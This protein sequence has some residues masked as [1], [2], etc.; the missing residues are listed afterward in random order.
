MMSARGRLKLPS[1]QELRD[2]P[3]EHPSGG[4]LGYVPGV[5]DNIESVDQFANLLKVPPAV[6][7]LVEPLKID[8]VVPNCPFK[9]VDRNG[10]MCVMHKRNWYPLRGEMGSAWLGPEF[11]R[12]TKNT[13]RPFHR[14]SSCNCQINACHLMGYCPLGY[15]YV[16]ENKEHRAQVM[17]TVG[18]FSS[19]TKR[20]VA[21]GDL[22][23][24][25]LAL[26]HFFGRH[27]EFNSNGICELKNSGPFADNEGVALNYPPPLQG[28]E[29]YLALEH[30]V[31]DWLRPQ[32]RWCESM[33]LLNPFPLPD[34][35]LAMLV[36]DRRETA[37]LCDIAVSSAC[38]SPSSPRK[39]SPSRAKLRSDSRVWRDRFLGMAER[40]IAQEARAIDAE[41]KKA[42]VQ[43]KYDDLVA[44]FDNM[45]NI[46]DEEIAELRK[47]IA[48]RD[49]KIEEMEKQLIDAKNKKGRPLRYSDLEEGGLLGDFVKDFTFFPSKKANDAF[50][51]MCNHTDG[52]DGSL[53]EGDGYFEN[54]RQYSKIRMP[55][56]RGEVQPPSYDPN[57]MAY[58]AYVAH[59]RASRLSFFTY[60]DEY[61]AWS[62]A[63]RSGMTQSAVRGL[64]GI[65]S[66]KMSDIVHGWTQVIDDA[67]QEMFPRPT[68][69]QMLQA[70][71]DRFYEAD[72]HC[73]TGL[74]LDAFELFVQQA[75]LPGVGSSTHSDYKKHCTAK[76]AG[77]VDVIGCPWDKTV[78]DGYPGAISDKILTIDTKILREVPFGGVAKV[79]KGFIVNNEGAEEGV[80]IDRPQV[81]M[82][83]QVQQS[84]E[85]TAQTQLLGNTRIVVE[86]VNGEM[87]VS[88][89]YLNA[90]IPVTQFGLVSQIVRI[91]Y[92]MQNFKKAVI[93]H[94]GPDEPDPPGGR[95]ARGE[96]RWYGAT[97]GGLSDYRPFVRAWGLKVEIKR[98]AELKIKHPNKSDT[99]ISEMVLAEDWPS[100]LRKSL[101]RI[102]GKDDYGNTRQAAS[103][104]N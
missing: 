73:R 53:P 30:N 42:E 37:K 18:L 17:N 41:A 80:D 70:Y 66:G 90:L 65:S 11:L 54:L 20:R 102:A 39:R 96:I 47:D 14:V 35:I 4:H 23:R 89:R 67:L 22:K 71:P 77:G 84:A 19:E 103:A 51:K 61:F 64:F 76:F 3:T 46:K 26:W 49:K 13:T 59:S 94:R 48:N 2:R 97:D 29:S 28:M 75:S 21:N 31:E 72:G 99:E 100:K 52:S 16:P 101:Y 36:T 6:L 68:R 15:V 40:A 93:Q 63:M 82:K 5:L 104:L 85:D 88:C 32:D 34:W 44:T 81:R 98:H 55:E 79:D 83:N 25:A 69:S 45:K 24:P 60:K 43:N 62:V 9:A 27:R 1:S 87:K 91:A 7:Y 58:Q 86:N 38:P 56:R 95:P 12:P 57:S 10:N 33:D 78:P 50:L 8:C 74:L 92:L